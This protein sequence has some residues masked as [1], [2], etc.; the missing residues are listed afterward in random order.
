MSG[1]FFKDILIADIN[2]KK[3]KYVQFQAGLNVVTSTE[4]HVGK[5]S[6][7]KSLYYC[8][9]AEIDFDGTWDK[10]NKLYAICVDVDGIEY[11][12]VRQQRKFLVF[13][14]KKLIHMCK[15]VGKELAPILEQIYGFSVYLPG[16]LT[17]KHELAPPVF[18]Y[19][20]YY[21]DQD[22]GWGSEPYES[23]ASLDQYKKDDRIKSLYYHLRVYTKWSVDI[24]SK[25]DNNKDRI[26]E[27]DFLQQKLQTTIETLL[28]E[29]NNLVPAETLEELEKGLQLPKEKIKSLIKIVSE[30]RNNMQELQ[31]LLLQHYR[32]VDIIEEYRKLRNDTKQSTRLPLSICPDCG[33]EFMDELYNLIRKQ[34]SEQNEHYMIQQIKLI[35]DSVEEKLEV[36]K[37]NYISLMSELKAEEKQIAQTQDTYEIYVKQRGLR[38]SMIRIQE[39]AGEHLCEIKALKEDIKKLRKQLRDLPNQKEVD[40]KYIEYTRFNI[41]KLKAWDSEYENKI[42]LLKPLKGQGTLASKIILSQYIALFSTMDDLGINNV[43]FPFVVDSPRS[44]EPSKSSSEEI[45][46]II[47][48]ITSLPQIILV[49]MD[50]DDFDV[51][52]KEE[53]NIIRLTEERSLL[54]SDDYVKNESSIKTLVE[55]FN[56]VQ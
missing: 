4:N 37:Q 17:K 23:F 45:I 49:T 54:N 20:P 38:E 35:I 6:L 32:Q 48:G 53:I 46:N 3:A 50:F 52:Q 5:S 12:I 15:S 16:R 19:L 55:L 56:G 21:I 39:Q 27:V 47:L 28:P 44:K 24:Q 33:Y 29:I 14:E 13:K 40:E 42:G 25:I 26:A 43:R 34:Y 22:D 2:V 36:E 1:V 10:N 41:I 9:G 7:A 8:L 51:A 11:T 18:T 31:S 30:S